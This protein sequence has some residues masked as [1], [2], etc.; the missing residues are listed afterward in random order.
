ML[1]VLGG[2]GAAA[3]SIRRYGTAALAVLSIAF[4]AEAVITPFPV[5]AGRPVPGYATPEPRLYRPARAPQVYKEIG[6]LPA[7]VVVAELPLGIPDFDLRS[8]YYSLVHGRRVLN[9]YSGFF[10]PH[11]GLLALG[12]SDVIRQTEVALD[13][14]RS[15]GATHVVVHE[16]WFAEDRGTATT[17][18]L[19]ARGATEL[20]RDR[21]DVL[22]QLP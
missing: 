3:V 8:T 4:L 21:G 20:Y 19:T 16:S 17:A 18:A 11:Y 5:N 12:L 14:L 13:T 7:D 1:S 9:G 6:R 15:F 22:L 2:F 10:P